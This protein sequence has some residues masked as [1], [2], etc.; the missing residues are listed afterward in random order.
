MISCRIYKK[1]SL[2]FL[3]LLLRPLQRRNVGVVLALVRPAARA[4]HVGDT[5]VGDMILTRE[6][7]ETRGSGT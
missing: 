7:R 2:T 6:T 3:P 1:T 4:P 5:V